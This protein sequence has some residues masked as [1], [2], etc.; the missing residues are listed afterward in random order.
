VT[1]FDRCSL[2]RL[3]EQCGFAIVESRETTRRM[4]EPRAPRLELQRKELQRGAAT[5]DRALLRIVATASAD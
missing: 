3:L 5:P 4:Y 2:E 1:R